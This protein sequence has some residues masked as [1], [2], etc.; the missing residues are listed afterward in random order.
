[1]GEYIAHHLSGAAFSSFPLKDAAGSHACS[2][3]H[4]DES[5]A[6]LGSF[7][8]GHQIADHTAAGH[9][10]RMSKGDGAALR[11]ELFHG[12]AELLDAVG[13]LRGERLVNLEN[14][15]VVH[16]EAAVL[17]G[18]R[19]GEC[20]SNTHDLRWHTGGG[21]AYNTADDSASKLDGNISTCQENAGGTVGNLA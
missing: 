21:E 9:T 11:V 16:G 6:L 2:N 17:E 7:K 13:G 15:D 1:M 12:D 8:L 3:A 5:K 19:D 20:G 4:G 14:V 10:E 18:S